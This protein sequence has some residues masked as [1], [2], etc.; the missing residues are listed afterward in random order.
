M[1]ALRKVNAPAEPVAMESP[2]MRHRPRPAPQS[3]YVIVMLVLFMPC[4][5]TNPNRVLAFWD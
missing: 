3:Q 4:R 5:L 2:G 1:S